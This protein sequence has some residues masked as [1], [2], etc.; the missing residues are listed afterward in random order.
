MRFI[1]QSLGKIYQTGVS[2]HIEAL[3]PAVQYPVPVGTPMI[4]SM[5]RWDHSQ[6]WPVID[7]KTLSAAGGGQVPT[8]SSYTVDPFASDS[9]ET[10]LLD[11]VIDGRVLYPFTGHM[12]LAWKTIAKLNGVDFQKT[13][14]ILEE[15]RVYSATIVTKP[16]QWKN[17]ILST[18]FSGSS[19]FPNLFN[20]YDGHEYLSLTFSPHSCLSNK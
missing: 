15:I 12:V 6:D 13:P 2:I 17:Y 10:F 3:Y 16:C 14:V 5:W 20:G 7:G 4:S 9:K 11:H 8:S 18:C 1:L 19:R